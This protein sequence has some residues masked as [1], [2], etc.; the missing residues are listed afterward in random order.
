MGEGT[1]YYLLISRGK[2]RIADGSVTEKVKSLEIEDLV[3]H[4]EGRITGRRECSCPVTRYHG[5][6]Y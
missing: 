2:G 6:R 3:L 5:E 1:A 4:E